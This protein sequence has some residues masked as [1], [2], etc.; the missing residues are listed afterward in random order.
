MRNARF[1]LLP[2]M[3]LSGLFAGCGLSDSPAE[4]VA[5]AKAH[6]EKGEFDSASIE[7]SNALQEAPN[8]AEARWLMADVA[9]HLGDGMRAEKEVRKAVELGHPLASAHVPLARAILLQGDL[10]RVIA[11]T[12]SLPRDIAQADRAVL[13]GLRGQAFVLKGDIG[14]AQPVLEQALRLEPK[15]A[16]ALIGMAALELY[17]RNFDEARRHALAATE[18]APDS[19]EAWSVLGEIE[20]ASGKPAEAESAFTRAIEARDYPSIDQAKRGLARVQQAKFAQAQADVQALQRAGL[21]DNSYVNYVAGLIAFQQQQFAEAERAFEAS[22]AAEPGFLPNRMYLAVTKLLQGQTQQAFTHAQYVYANAQNSRA[23]RALLSTIQ[24]SRAEYAA[25]RDLMTAAL[26]RTPDDTATLRMLATLALLEGDAKKGVEYSTRLASLLPESKE[27]QEMLMVAK[28][29]G[30]H[31]LGTVQND[32]AGGYKQAFLLALEA[33]RDRKLKDALE[34]ATQLHEQHPDKVDPIN[35][36]AACHLAVGDWPAAKA[37]LVKALELEPGEPSAT[38][39]LAKVE[40]QENDP[41]RAK[42]LLEGLLKEHPGDEEAALLLADIRMRLDGDHAAATA[43]LEGVIRHSP[44]AL[45]ARARLAAEHLRAGRVA[46]AL[47]ATQD[48]SG[49]QY[50]QKPQ[51]LELRGKALA[52]AGDFISARQVFEQWTRA[53]PNLAAPHFYLSDALARS[54]HG[55]RAQRALERAIAIDSKYLPAR[56]G[57]VKMLV[58]EGEIKKAERALA[59]LRPDFGNQPEILGIEGWFALGMRDFPAAER[60]FSAALEQRADPELTILLARALWGQQKH[61]RSIEVLQAWTKEHPQDVAVLLQLAETLVALRRDAD[62]AAT[63]AK[64]TEVFPD[65]ISA[66]NALAW[67]NREKKPAE[68]MEYAQRAYKLAPKNPNVLDTLA[69]LALN[70]GD[71]GRAYKLLS[72]A[73]S[74]AP[75][76]PQIQLHLGN[77]L[78]QQKRVGEAREVLAALVKHSPDGEP[79]KEAKVILESLGNGR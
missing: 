38:R 71:T 53:Q 23:A 8:T 76:D 33:F 28:L 68:A 64:I 34:R 63:Y 55:L 11:E 72:E 61:D 24:I 78:V 41:Q 79:A 16:P 21:K 74:L 6:L 13:L 59:K 27:M 1:A 26:Q 52:L 77:V 43:L 54:G 46:K 73:A 32:D 70:A 18:S 35:L 37:A 30:G 39:N 19:A 62:A 57:E 9:L 10:E 75:S 31:K 60:H 12:A 36:I 56:V 49:G 14:L 50:A 29:I 58:Q 65:H 69:I 17:R 2:I 45:E 4:Y 48:L 15:S 51:L 3:V 5:K 25:A 7:L 42:V 44:E 22:H 67:L 20:L 66:L 47:E 40:L